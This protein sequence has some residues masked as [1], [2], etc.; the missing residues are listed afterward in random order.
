MLFT[1]FLVVLLKNR[2][3]KT[4]KQNSKRKGHLSGEKQPILS[5]S[6]QY[7]Q[8]YTTRMRRVISPDDFSYVQTLICH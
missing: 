8:Y 2:T 3:L 1:S 7:E 4:V 6:N 5:K